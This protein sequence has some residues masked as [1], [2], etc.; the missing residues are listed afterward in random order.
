MTP[1]SLANPVA[2]PVVSPP[3]TYLLT[4]AGHLDNRWCDWLG[5]LSLAH[6]DDATSTI[7]LEAADQA[8][9]HG[10]LAAI[11]DIGA[12][13]ISVRTTAETA[14]RHSNHV[15]TL[16]RVLHTERLTLRPATAYDAQATWAYRQ[17]DS[18][19]EWLTGVPASFAEYRGTFVE[20]SRLAATVIVEMT[21]DAGAHVLGDFMLRIEDAWAQA[22]VAEGA[23]GA[24]AELGWVLDPAYTG[25]GFATEAVVELLRYCFEELDVHR[26]VANCFL[27][28]DTSWRLMQRVGMRRE[29]HAVQES[30]HRSGQWLDT[31]GYAV[32]DDEWKI[33]GPHS[34][35]RPQEST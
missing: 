2:N 12:T 7:R 33:T 19:N 8:H 16:R 32:L 10:L 14:A 30:L 22:E 17:L 18:V 20:S 5:G 9:L 6:N 3:A 34:P 1:A 21:D 23:K 25:V 24:Q 15:P 31:V 11:R 13:L 35:S 29:M 28:N 27:G 4:V 26:V